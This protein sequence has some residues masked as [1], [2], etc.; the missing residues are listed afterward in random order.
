MTQEK[1][2]KQ[3]LTT[4]IILLSI[5][6]I[7]LIAFIALYIDEKN[8]VQETYQQRFEDNLDRVRED[9]VSYQEAEADYD[10]RYMRL[11]IDMSNAK[12]FAFLIHDFNDKQIIVNELYTILIKYLEQM[13]EEEKLEAL[14]TAVDDI[15]AHL[16]K[17]Y[18][19][20]EALIDSIDKKGH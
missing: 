3:R 6:L 19:E 10:M 16:D 20:A 7:G 18:E 8:R 14:Y 2:M 5:T 13:Q 12:E 11:T 15:L 1:L 4:A 9:I 17:G